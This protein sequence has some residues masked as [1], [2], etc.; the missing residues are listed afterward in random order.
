MSNEDIEAFVRACVKWACFDAEGPCMD[1]RDERL[2]GDLVMFA[3]LSFNDPVTDKDPKMLWDLFL[4]TPAY[5]DR[6]QAAQEK[7][8]TP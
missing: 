6:T 8:T 1:Y 4:A 2:R 5:K 7:D 3:K